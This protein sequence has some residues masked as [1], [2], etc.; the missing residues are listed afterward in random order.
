MEKKIVFSAKKWAQENIKIGI[1]DDDLKW[2]LE[3]HG[4]TPKEM[5]ELGYVCMNRWTIEVE[6]EE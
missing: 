2:V 1:S 3:C 6:V 5:E 4:K